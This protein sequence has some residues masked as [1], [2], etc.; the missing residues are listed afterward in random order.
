MS[1]DR[2]VFEKSEDG[3]KVKDRLGSL[4]LSPFDREVKLY[5]G[6]KMVMF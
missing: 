3:L 2:L 6:Q 1:S 5:I 4:Q